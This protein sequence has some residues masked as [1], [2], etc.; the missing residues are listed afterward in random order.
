MQ[1]F[2]NCKMSI[3]TLE[4]AW[5]GTE[6]AWSADNGMGACAGSTGL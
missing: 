4:E 1:M 2:G 6:E 5:P 3:F